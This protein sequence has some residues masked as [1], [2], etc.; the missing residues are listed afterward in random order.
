MDVPDHA[1]EQIGEDLGGTVTVGL[2]QSGAAGRDG[3]QVVQPVGMAAE[4]GLDLAQAGGTGEL[5]I[6]HGDEVASVAEA[7]GAIL[8]TVAF[9]G[10]LALIPGKQLQQRMKD[11]I[12]G[13]HGIDLLGSGDVAKRRKLSRINAVR[14]GQ[15]NVAIRTQKPC[16]TAV[17][18][19]RP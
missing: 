13:R 4:T 1:S 2:G 7:A 5:G 9:D 3:A 12:V 17:G 16:Q 11:A 15:Q 19:A 18:Q 14:F 8:G 6:Q 10:A